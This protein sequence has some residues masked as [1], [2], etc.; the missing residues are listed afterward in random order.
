[1]D[2]IK[3][4]IADDSDFVRDG[5]RIIL[6]MDEDFQVVGC[7]KNG[8]EAIALSLKNKVDIILMDIQMPEVDGIEAT[9]EIVKK[10]LG[11]VLVLTTFDDYDL[12]EKA[13]QNGAKGYL[14]KNHTPEKLKQMIKSLYNG[15]NVLDEKVFEKIAKRSNYMN[16]GFDNSIFTERELE[17][18]EAVAEGLSNKEIA[19]K[20]F[21]GEGTVKNHIST[22]LEKG[23]LS[24]RTQLAV[25][26]LT[27][28]R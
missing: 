4:V 18:I 7:A 21:I 9:R 8:R 5:L 12:V 19:A 26:Y 13:I 6:D 25:Y 2:K 10:S 16:V 22:I 1:M 28:K 27:G 20:L 14:I 3:I 11:K 15:V 23:N 17:I 24:H